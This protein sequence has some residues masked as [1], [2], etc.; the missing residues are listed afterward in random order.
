LTGSVAEREASFEV[1]PPVCY[2]RIMRG[3]AAI[4]IVL[5]ACVPFA[6]AASARSKS[7]RP[8]HARP[9]ASE[10]VPGAGTEASSDSAVGQLDRVLSTRIK[11]ICRGC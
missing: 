4:A 6:D 1:R 11:S 7:Q 9:G 10:R 8:Q 5:A 2:L 3:V